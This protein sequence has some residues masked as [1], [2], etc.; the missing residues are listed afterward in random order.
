M[1]N[2]SVRHF[3]KDAAAAVAALAGGFYNLFFSHNNLRLNNQ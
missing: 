2:D 1:R 3:D